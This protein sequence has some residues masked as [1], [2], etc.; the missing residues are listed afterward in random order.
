MSYILRCRG[1]SILS[2]KEEKHQDIGIATI[3]IETLDSFYELELY[4]KK[5]I[6][7]Q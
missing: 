6:I 5:N 7:Q 3:S 2:L 1:T 4:W